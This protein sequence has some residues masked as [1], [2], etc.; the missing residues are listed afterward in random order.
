MTRNTQIKNTPNQK[1]N[2]GIGGSDGFN[3]TDFGKEALLVGG[4]TFAISFAVNHYYNNK[5]IGESL[6]KSKNDVFNS[7]VI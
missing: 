2:K 5:P 4:V 6:N 3:L 7:L 1:L